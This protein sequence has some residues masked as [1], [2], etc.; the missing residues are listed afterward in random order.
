ANTDAGAALQNWYNKSFD[1]AKTELQAERKSH[2]DLKLN[3]YNQHVLTK[4]ENAVN[5]IVAKNQ[6]EKA[7]KKENINAAKNSHIIAVNNKEDQ[8]SDAMA[9]Q[10]DQLYNYNKNIFNS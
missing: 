7:E 10:F 3:E 6:A 2:G 9:A 8:I 5:A 4:G 1:S